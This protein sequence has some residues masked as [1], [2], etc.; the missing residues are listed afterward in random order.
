MKKHYPVTIFMTV[1]IAVVFILTTHPVMAAKS[2]DPKVLIVYPSD[3]KEI[4]EQQ[5]ILDM[6]ISHFTTDIDFKQP[7][8]IEENDLEIYS[9]VFYQGTEKEDLPKGFQKALDDYEGTIVA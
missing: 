9:H 5:R 7:D 1:L 2:S 4:N 3:Q 6:L 8:E